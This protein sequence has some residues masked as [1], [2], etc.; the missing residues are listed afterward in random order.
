MAQT[1]TSEPAVDIP[2][3]S[4]VTVILFSTDK[5]AFPFVDESVIC[6]VPAIESA[7]LGT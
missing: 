7:E 3:G 4:I 5:Q 6:T 2:A 1:V